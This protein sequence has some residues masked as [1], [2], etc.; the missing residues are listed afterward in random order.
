[1]K[2]EIHPVRVLGKGL[3]LFVLINILYALI[4]PSLGQ[5][6]AY[7][8]IFPGRTRFPFGV[9]TNPYSLMVND[10]DVMFA[11]H[12]ISAPKM[13]GEYR[14]ILIGDSSIWGESISIHNTISEQWNRK[15]DTCGN[16]EIQFYNLG[17]PHPSVIKDLLILDKAMEYNP[18]MVVWFVTGNTLIPRRSNPLLTTNRERTINLLDRHG[19]VPFDEDKLAFKEPSFYQKTL[20]GERSELARLLKLQGLGLL[21]SITR[22]DDRIS[23]ETSMLSPDVKA[24][25][26]Y[27]GWGPTVNLKKKI[28]FEALSAGHAMAKS[29]PV[30]VVNEPIY[31]AT[32]QNSDIR[33]NY[34][35]P[36]WAY[37]QYREALA[38]E[39]QKA[40][41]N[42]LDLWD[43]VPVNNFAD[44]GLHPSADGERLM[45]QKIDPTLRA[46]ACP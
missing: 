2:A 12:V 3:I 20:W 18:D 10:L 1:M 33:Y 16:R 27:R 22:Q 32:G 13:P 30:L 36:R 4:D 34:I 9:G 31:I 5:V 21:W 40:G 7:N 14:V 45:I 41:W 17:Y 26:T 8:T 29:I 23:D 15:D 25:N 24:S 46:I 35:Y 44:T 6:S 28:M 38:A 39:V 43:A 19:I 42:Y 11:S 37:D